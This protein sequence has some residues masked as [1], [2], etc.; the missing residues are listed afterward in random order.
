M[1]VFGPGSKNQSNIFLEFLMT[2]S[3]VILALEPCCR[4]IIIESNRMSCSS[5]IGARLAVH[6]PRSDFLFSRPD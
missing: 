2:L 6:N 5:L 3:K 4:I 1:Y